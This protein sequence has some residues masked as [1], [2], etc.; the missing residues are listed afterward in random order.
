MSIVPFIPEA[1][2][3]NTIVQTKDKYDKNGDKVLLLNADR[4]QLQDF[5]Q[6]KVSN[7][8]YDLRVGSSYW[9]VSKYDVT[10]LKKGVIKLRPKMYMEIATEEEMRF[11][12][13]RAGR[14]SSKVSILRKGIGVFPTNVDPGYEGI[15]VIYVCNFGDDTVE[16]KRGDRFC[17]LKVETVGALAHS[18]D[19]KGKKPEGKEKEGFKRY[20]KWFKYHAVLISLLLNILLLITTLLIALFALLRLA[21]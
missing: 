2:T 19:K 12:L 13:N 9:D 14:I 21:K 5:D 1:N 7:T 10:P 8:S 6:G 4:K 20:L 17:A 18:Y 15:L 3:N 11:P 16:L